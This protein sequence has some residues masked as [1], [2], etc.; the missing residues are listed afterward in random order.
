MLSPDPIPA[1]AAAAAAPVSAAAASGSFTIVVRVLLLGA[2]F[3]EIT[4]GIGDQGA[5]REH[6]CQD[7]SATSLR[8][9]QL[10]AHI[11]HPHTRAHARTHYTRTHTRTHIGKRRQ[12]TF[13][14]GLGRLRQLTEVIVAVV[15]RC[16]ST[17]VLQH[18]ETTGHE[19]KIS[20]K[21]FRSTCDQTGLLVSTACKRNIAFT[22]K[23]WAQCQSRLADAGL[24]GGGTVLPQH[25]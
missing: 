15:V 24:G 13:S 2:S 19:D 21:S 14:G 6:C 11:P 17:G 9:T 23:F 5:T 1:A 7:V 12:L 10:L 22:Q 20:T 3:T 25:L 8:R 18:S 4:A 16:T